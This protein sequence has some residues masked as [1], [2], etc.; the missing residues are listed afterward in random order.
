MSEPVIAQCAACRVVGS[1]AHC[2]ACPRT[3]WQ[4]YA[5]S[6]DGIREYARTSGEP[7][8]PERY[9]PMYSG[10][11]LL[12][13]AGFRLAVRELGAAEAEVAAQAATIRE[14]KEALF[15]AR[16]K[17]TEV[18]DTIVMYRHKYSERTYLEGAGRVRN[19]ISTIIDAAL[20]KEDA[21]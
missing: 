18:V 2:D 3:P 6:E 13:K 10:R 17:A 1:N 12:T 8:I 16:R 11:A 15:E 4:E 7:V 5:T 9:K 21:L 19:E 14:L 20:S